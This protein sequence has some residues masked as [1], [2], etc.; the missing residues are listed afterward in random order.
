[1]R[2]DAAVVVEDGEG[3]GGRILGED[4]RRRSADEIASLAKHHA[5]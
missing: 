5:P 2:I 3:R 1:V 4:C